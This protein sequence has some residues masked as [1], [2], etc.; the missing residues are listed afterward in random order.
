MPALARTSESRTGQSHFLAFAHYSG[1]S[2]HTGHGNLERY[3]ISSLFKES[4]KSSGIF[5][6]LEKSFNS[7][8]IFVLF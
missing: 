7:H 1:D 8:G 2:V 6:T 4:G 3:G 5:S